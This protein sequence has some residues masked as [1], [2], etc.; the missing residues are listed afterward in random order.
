MIILCK[1]FCANRNDLKLAQHDKI[2]GLGSALQITPI[3][4]Q[5][6]IE[7]RF[8]PDIEIAIVETENVE[9]KNEAKK[10]ITNVREER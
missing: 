7:R 8:F 6:R 4:V 2:F 10:T 3:H 5:Y 1:Y 9:T